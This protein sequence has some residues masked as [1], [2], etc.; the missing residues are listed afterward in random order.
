MVR[1][2]GVSVEYDRQGDVV[3]T[4]VHQD[5]DE[6]Y[7]ANKEEWHDAFI[8]LIQTMHMPVR[9]LKFKTLK[10]YQEGIVCEV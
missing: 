9:S 5:A 3:I 2:E 8:K 10:E 6:A 1:R 4:F 7:Q